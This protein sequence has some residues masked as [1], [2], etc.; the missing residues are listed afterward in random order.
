MI[1]KNN[2]IFLLVLI[3]SI[4]FQSTISYS[5]LKGL[6]QLDMESLMKED[7]LS[8]QE[9]DKIQKMETMPVGN[10]INPDFYYVG[11]GDIFA[12]QNLSASTNTQYL[13]VSP[14]NSVML[15]RIGEISLKGKTLT[16][17]KKIITD[18]IKQRNPNS[19][20]SLALFKPRTVLITIK[21]DVFSEGTLSLPATYN[22]STAYKLSALPTLSSK[23]T[24]PESISYLKYIEKKQRISKINAGTGS[25]IHHHYYSRNIYIK[26]SDGTQQTADI[27]KATAFNNPL[28]DPYIKEGD[29]ILVPFEPVS[30]QEISISGGVLNPSTLPFK[31][32]DKASMLL[33]IAGGLTD[34]ADID[35]IYLMMEGNSEKIKL[36][37]D[38]SMNLMNGDYDLNAG[39]MI[40]VGKKNVETHSQLGMVAISGHIKSPGVYPIK[41]GKTKLK[42]IIELA[43]G[44]TDDAYLPLSNI[45]RK[46]NGLSYS[47]NPRTEIDEKFQYSDLTLQDTVRFNIDQNLKLPIVSCDFDA[48]FKSNSQSDNISLFDGDLI[49]IPSNPGSVFVYGQVNK[50]GYVPFENGK[51]M[52]W[53]LEKAGGIAEGGKS[54]RTRI[55]RGKNNTWAEGDNDVAVFGGDEIY[56]PRAEDTPPG[57]DLQKWAMIVSVLGATAAVINAVIWAIR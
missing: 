6:S 41:N 45:Y 42:E 40:L 5:Q 37:I 54:G 47:V 39:S 17:T 28:Y 1:K 16:E 24:M 8:N 23:T 34:E 13:I 29:E 10:V 21:G 50:P 57:T 52:D 9:S 35:N 27:I 53:Y 4:I 31:E 48:L 49:V 14:E 43:G 36:N 18:I 3:L 55:I 7:I 15:P 19:L 56:V 51:N 12:Y 38:S 2:V 25:P 22:V 44:F 20:S 30:Y 33:K 46:F 11:P 32:G 26:H